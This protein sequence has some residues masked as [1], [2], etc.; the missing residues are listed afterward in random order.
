MASGD[1]SPG[2][3]GVPWLEEVVQRLTGQCTVTPERA[4]EEIGQL[5]DENLELVG[6]RIFEC[7]ECGWY[8]EVDEEL[9]NETGE[10]LCSECTEEDDG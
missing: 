3:G 7:A 5:S 6:T 10:D 2:A 4:L 8:A 9:H 1:T